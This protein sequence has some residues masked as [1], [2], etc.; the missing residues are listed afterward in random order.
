MAIES[1]RNP[2][3]NFFFNVP[4]MKGIREYLRRYNKNINAEIEI[5]NARKHGIKFL[6]FISYK[7]T[8][9]SGAVAQCRIPNSL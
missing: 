6:S 1:G 7:I 8:V 2:V 5:L 3:G 9:R 4:G